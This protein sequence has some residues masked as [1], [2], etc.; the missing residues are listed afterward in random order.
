MWIKGGRVSSL[1]L[2]TDSHA[3]TLPKK[4]IILLGQEKRTSNL[5]TT[6][7]HALTTKI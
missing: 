6:C 3:M 2:K 5:Q 7:K 1:N 4:S